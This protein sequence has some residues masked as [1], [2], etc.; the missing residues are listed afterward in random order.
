M[1][2]TLDAELLRS[3]VAIA[4]TGGFTRAAERVHRTQSA[5]S[6]QIKRLEETLGQPLFEREGR[7]V[8]LTPQGELLLDHARRI[9]RAHHEAIAAFDTHAV[10]G[11]VRFGSPDDYASTFLPGIL[12]RFARSHP[13][14]HVEVVVD[15]SV[16][17]LEMQAAGDVDLALVSEGSGE[18]GGVLVTREPVVW[19][20]SARHC[21]H[22]QE[23]LPLAIFHKGCVFREA[24]LN[25]LDGAGRATRIAYSSISLSGLLAAVEAGLAVGTVIRG[26]VRPGLRILTETDGFP[27][28]PDVGIKLQRAPSTGGCLI[29]R[30]EEHVVDSFRNAAA[31]AHAAA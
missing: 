17:L 24:A 29:D 4:E 16:R 11:R 26:N 14:V 8:A 31:T 10:R 1:I 12:A 30:L 20:T 13:L 25:A 19:V 5:V 23:P 3:F 15:S 2:P 6:M 27:R 18:A 9:L 28:L 22:E 21:I 7:S